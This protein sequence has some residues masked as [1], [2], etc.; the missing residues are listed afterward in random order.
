MTYG[1]GSVNQNLPA[2]VVLP[3]VSYP[4]GGSPNWGNGFL[5]ANYQG[6]ALRAAGV[7][8]LD[9]QP[10]PEIAPEHQRANLDLL[11]S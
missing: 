10:P 3:E 5:P 7:P 4:Q 9:L 1:L 6:T 8:I 11:G 2:F